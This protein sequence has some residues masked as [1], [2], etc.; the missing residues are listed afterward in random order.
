MNKKIFLLY[1]ECNDVLNYITKHTLD[2]FNIFTI[3]AVPY[4]ISVYIQ[5]HYSVLHIL[6]YNNEY[7][8]MYIGFNTIDEYKIFFSKYGQ[9]MFEHSSEKSAYDWYN[10]ETNWYFIEIHNDKGFDHYFNKWREAREWLVR[11]V[12][13]CFETVQ[14][15]RS[16]DC[17]YYKILNKEDAL[18]F[19]VIFK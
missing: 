14:F 8:T 13:N 16:G 15:L 19:K 5:D 18:R 11:N 17:Q 12:E 2:D 6:H 10:N 3:V 9:Y 7:K 4:N 1:C